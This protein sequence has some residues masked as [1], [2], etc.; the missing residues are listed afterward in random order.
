MAQLACE[1]CGAELAPEQPA[2]LVDG[3]EEGDYT[4]PAGYRYRLRFVAEAPGA[5]ASGPASHE[6]SW[7]PS[8]TWQ[9][10]F[11]KGCSHHV[12]WLFRSKTREFRGLIQ[13]S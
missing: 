8:Y 13:A 12:G 10:L 7:F 6:A 11:C 3:Q 1:R 5:V 2:I 9:R 4:N